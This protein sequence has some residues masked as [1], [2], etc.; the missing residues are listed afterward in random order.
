MKCF[1][2]CKFVSQR[3]RAAKFFFS[4]RFQIQGCEAKSPVP[5]Y[6]NKETGLYFSAMQWLVNR[7]FLF[8]VQN[9]IKNNSKFYISD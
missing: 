2:V 8:E 5:S 4:S 9:Q 3:K 6:C 1:S 7:S